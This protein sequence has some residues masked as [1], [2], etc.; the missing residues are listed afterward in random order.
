MAPGT[1]PLGADNILGFLPGLLVAPG[2]SL[3]G[4][5][6]SSLGLPLPVHGGKL[7]VEEILALRSAGAGLDGLF[8]TGKSRRP[9]FIFIDNDNVDP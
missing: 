8:I 5:S 2:P 6:W 1:D 4:D 9:E 3:V 7:I